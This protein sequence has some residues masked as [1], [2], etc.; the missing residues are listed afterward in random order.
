M[1]RMFVTLR[2]GGTEAVVWGNPPRFRF[3]PA[4]PPV[5]GGTTL[6]GGGTDASDRIER[7]E[8]GES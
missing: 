1:V 8:G 6:R 5:S 3:A 2:G 7:V 4:V